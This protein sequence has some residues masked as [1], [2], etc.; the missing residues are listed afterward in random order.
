[1]CVWDWIE[2][3]RERSENA[4]RVWRILGADCVPKPWRVAKGGVGVVGWRRETR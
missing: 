2:L 3:R 4:G 1:M